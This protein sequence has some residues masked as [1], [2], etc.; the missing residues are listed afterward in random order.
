V[1]LVS[2]TTPVP[3]ERLL[4]GAEVLAQ[5]R[6]QLVCDRTHTVRLTLLGR[7]SHPLP[8]SGN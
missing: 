6:V 2:H 5:E 4:P 8:A 3:W 1:V 7:G